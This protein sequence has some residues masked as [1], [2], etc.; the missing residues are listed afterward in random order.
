MRTQIPVPS[1]GDGLRASW[2]AAVAS[3]VNELCAMA[4]AGMLSREGFGGMGAQPLPQNLRDRAGGAGRPMPFDIQA[5]IQANQDGTAQR[6]IIKCYAGSV[7]W[8]G[9]GSIQAA[10]SNEPSSS[11]SGGW[12]TVFNGEWQSSSVTLNQDILLA[13]KIT[14]NPEWEPLTSPVTFGTGTAV[15][16]QVAVNAAAQSFDNP[17]GNEGLYYAANT[18]ILVGSVSLGT[19]AATLGGNTSYVTGVQKYHGNL[20]LGD[21][22][23]VNPMGGDD[24]DEDPT[25]GTTYPMPFQYK[26]TDTEDSQGDITSTYA[27]VNNRFYWD[28]EYHTLA[29]YT[30]PA[31]GTVYLVA[32]RSGTGAGSWSFFLATATRASGSTSSRAR[33][34]RWTTARPP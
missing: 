20:I 12:I 24:S 15:L 23:Q 3:R 17:Y 33:R 19:V 10:I 25:S 14:L 27:I 26:R 13:Y 18:Q 30:P 7:V 5:S 21:I 8:N 32:R 28:G 9:F 29:D 1:K 11:D 22:L 31:T 34:S 4:P 16:C 2:G 6:L